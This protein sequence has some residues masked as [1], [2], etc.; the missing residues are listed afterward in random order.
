MLFKGACLAAASPLA[1][2]SRSQLSLC[3]SGPTSLGP[4][5][6]PKSLS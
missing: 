2:A 4:L 5:N 1:T 6:N 3:T